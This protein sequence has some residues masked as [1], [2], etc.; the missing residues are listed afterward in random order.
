MEDEG[1]LKTNFRAFF[2]PPFLPR[3]S[4]SRTDPKREGTHLGRGLKRSK[5]LTIHFGT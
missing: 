2:L 1:K 4:G 3:F 5:T